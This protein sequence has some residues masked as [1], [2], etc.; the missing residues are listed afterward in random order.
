MLCI[1]VLLCLHSIVVKVRRG[2][3]SRRQWTVVDYSGCTLS[4]NND[5]VFVIISLWA[6]VT[7]TSDDNDNDV[8]LDLP[9]LEGQVQQM[10]PSLCM[11]YTLYSSLHHIL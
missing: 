1:I 3:M 5:L 9:A 2:C 6:T 11:L 10:M 7:S 8:T 4:S